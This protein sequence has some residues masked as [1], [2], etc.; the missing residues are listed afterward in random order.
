MI[1]TTPS[2]FGDMPI[3][4]RQTLDSLVKKIIVIAIHTLIGWALCAAIIGIGI[5]VTTMETTL[6]V[7]VI[8]VPIIFGIISLFYFSKFN[9]TTPLVT[10]IIYLGSAL[11]IDFF[12]VALL[13]EKSF[14]MF[15]SLIG[16]W[17]PFV[18]IFLSAYIV[19]LI[20]IK[21]R[22]KSI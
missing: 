17:I 3:K 4:R 16:T 8:G 15:K 13:L 7:H 21:T 20:V 14:D 10:G 6:I 2:L 18:L 9:Y 5:N 19:G 22:T 1:L 11:L 12:V